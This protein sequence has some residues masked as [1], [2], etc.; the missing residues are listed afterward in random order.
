MRTRYLFLVPLLLATATA[1][2]APGLSE[3]DRAY[4]A[5]ADPQLKAEFGGAYDGPQ[6]A[7]VRA[8]G[9]RI[10]LQSGMAARASDYTV[11]LLNSNVNNAFAVQG[12]YVY[13]TRQLVALMNN[14]AELAFV[15]GH[16]VGHVAARHSQKREQRSTLTSLGAA[17]LGAVTGSNIIGNLAGTGAQLYTLGYS[18]DQE[19]EADSLGVRYL[20]RAGYDPMASGDI[21]ASLGAVT[22]LE[23]RLEGKASAEPV[24]WLSTHPGSAERVARIRKEAATFAARGGQRLT[25]RDAFLNAIDG[26]AYDD[27]PAQG[28][29]KGASFRHPGLGVAFDAPQGF[30]LQNSPSQVTGSKPQA[31]K[32]SFAGAT[33]RGADLASYGAKLW[34][35]AGATAPAPKLVRINGIDAAISQT[36]AT[37][38]SGTVDATLAVYR[39]GPDQYYHLLM[40]A[41]AGGAAMF[42]PLIESVRRMSAADAA[43]IRSRR[44][45]VVTVKP[46]DTVATLSNRMA[47]DDDRVGRFAVLNGLATNSRLVPGARVKLIVWR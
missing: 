40:I 17:I 10:A 38:R 34:E 11:T 2:Q 1:A 5:K 13:V 7:Y 22:S 45:S 47:Y 36:R 3:T 46:G 16:E 35:A 20:V 30:A 28:I 44:V 4:G 39:W 31:G 18:R 43:A 42:Q 9:Q 26:M 41:P 6:A 27:D 14:E 8:V 12:G 19:R 24:G 25:N 23:A 33:L 21:L 32:F 15:M 37:T 29:I